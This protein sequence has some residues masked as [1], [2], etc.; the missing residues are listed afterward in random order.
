MV[1]T[2]FGAF[3]GAFG[4]IFGALGLTFGALGGHL[5][6]LG[7]HFC[8]FGQKN[9][10]FT[11]Y[12]RNQCEIYD[13]GGRVGHFSTLGEPKVA[14][15]GPKSGSYNQLWTPQCKLNKQDQLWTPGVRRVYVI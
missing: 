1:A 12:R 13:F 9:V 10:I 3:L 6:C 2:Y 8:D 11:K 14:E 5:G 4:L 7:V 15:K